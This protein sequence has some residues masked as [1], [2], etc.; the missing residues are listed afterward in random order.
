MAERLVGLRIM[1]EHQHFLQIAPIGESEARDLMEK[2]ESGWGREEAHVMVTGT[3]VTE[4]GQTWRYSIPTWRVVG[5]HTFNLDQPVQGFTQQ[6]PVPGVHPRQP[7]F[8]R[9]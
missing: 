4:A 8:G 6:S 7:Y 5:M 1:L 3:S 9:S 2:I